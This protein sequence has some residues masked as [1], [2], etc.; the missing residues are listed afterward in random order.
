[1]KKFIIA[2][3]IAAFRGWR[4]VFAENIKV[5]VTPGEHAQIME[6]VAE[7]AKTKGLNI[8]IVEF[9]D[10]VAEPGAQRWRHPGQL[11]PAPALSRQPDRR[12]QVRSRQHRHDDH[13]ADG[14][15]FQEGEEPR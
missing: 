3:A 8:E 7:I 11:V 5:G 15:L 10:R 13:H 4:P 12:P 1:M 14:R 9:S 6:K 2:V